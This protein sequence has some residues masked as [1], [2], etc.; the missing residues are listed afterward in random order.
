MFVNKSSVGCLNEIYACAKGNVYK[1][2]VFV[3]RSLSAVAP[4]CD[5]MSVFQEKMVRFRAEMDPILKTLMN[6][7]MPPGLT[8][9]Q[10]RTL[11]RQL[12]KHKIEGKC[13]MHH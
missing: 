5:K 13:L 2:I 12:N 11:R 8:E 6:G 3:C 7:D 9:N 1:H 10:K 4:L